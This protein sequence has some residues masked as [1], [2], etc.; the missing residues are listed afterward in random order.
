MW[1]LTPLSTIFNLY[2]G[3][4]FY[5][6]RKQYITSPTEKK[7]NPNFSFFLKEKIYII[8]NG[9]SR[10]RMVV[11]FITTYPISAHHH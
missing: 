6:L 1:C 3:G 10:D 11:G 2:H 4:Q 5:W 9:G 8:K 7:Y